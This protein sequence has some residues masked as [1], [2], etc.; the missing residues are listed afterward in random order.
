MLLEVLLAPLLV[1]CSTVACRRW[2]AQTGGLISALPAV[3]G[4]VLLIVALDRGP[5]YAAQAAN[6]TLL[7]LVALAGFALAYAR[8]AIRARWSVSLAIGWVIAAG[9][10]APVGWMGGR[11]GFPAGLLVAVVSLSLARRALP[12][13]PVG[14]AV[15]SI[16]GRGRSGVVVRMLVTAALVEVLAAAAGWFGPLVG[17][18]LAALPVL[19]SVL[20]VVTHRRDGATA[21]VDLLAGMLSG[22]VGFVGFCVVIALLVVPIGTAAA[23]SAAVVCALASQAL[24]LRPLPTLR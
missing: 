14:L 21:V 12:R 11:L 18:M 17:G 19:A 6:G 3:V 10:T 7:G 9:L 15:E 1:G 24:L 16:G 23:F 4:P 22:M 5:A 20:A 13:L 2:G 8:V